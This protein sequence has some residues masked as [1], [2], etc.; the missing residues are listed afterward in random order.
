M[1]ARNGTRQGRATQTMI[2]PVREAFAVPYN[3]PNI[4][5]W[6]RHTK[7]ARARNG[8]SRSGT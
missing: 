7:A 2:D 5:N 8:V 4:F 6:N 3:I 1:D